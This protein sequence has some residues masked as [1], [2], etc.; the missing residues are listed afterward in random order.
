MSVDAHFGLHL[1]YSV[2]TG[3]SVPHVHVHILPRAEGDFEENDDVYDELENWVP[4]N[5]MTKKKKKFDVPEE[6][7]DR[8]FDEM[9]QEASVFR[10]L[11]VSRD[12][13]TNS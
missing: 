2:T 7:V 5:D 1:N 10:E 4:T 8:S 11:I 3:Q 9:A 13:D 6:R 12:L